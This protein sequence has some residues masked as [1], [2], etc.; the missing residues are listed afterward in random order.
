MFFSD[1]ST[2]LFQDIAIVISRYTRK[3]EK[4]HCL[5][6]PMSIGLLTMGQLG[7]TMKMEMGEGSCL[8]RCIGDNRMLGGNCLTRSIIGTE[9]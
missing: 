4:V 6:K 3:K 7:Q 1:V 8:S 5:R 2:F 9:Y